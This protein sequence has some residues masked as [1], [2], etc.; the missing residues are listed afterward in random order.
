MAKVILMDGMAGISGKVGNMVFRTYKN[1]KVT[2]IPYEPKQRIT[3]PSA[4][5]MKNREAFGAATEAWNTMPATTKAYW[6]AEYMRD[7]ATFNGKR[8]V[9]L[10]GYFIARF[11]AEQKANQ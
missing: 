7:K 9:T 6:E 4:K 3:P 8:Y 5:E 2:C 10:H 11:M 1:G